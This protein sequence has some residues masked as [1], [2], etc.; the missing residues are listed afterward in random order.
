MKNNWIQYFSGVVTVKITG[1]GLER[2]LNSLLRNGITIWDVKRI[3][4]EAILFKM[5]LRDVS[6]LRHHVRKFDCKLSFQ[7]RTGLPFFVRKLMKNSGIVVGAILFLVTIFLLSNIVWDVEIEGASPETEYKIEKTLQ[8]IDVKRGKFL[9]LLDPPE[10]IQQTLTAQIDE[11][12]W[13]GV[14]L[15]GTTY[16]LQVVEK[17]VPEKPESYG[18]QNLVASKKAM[19]VDVFVEE[20]QPL[21]EVNDHVKAGQ[22]LVSG[23]IGT[24]EN[25]QYVSAKGEILGEIWYKTDVVLPLKN[26]LSVMTGEKMTK[27]YVNFGRF[28]IQVWGFEKVNFEQFKKEIDEKTFRFLKWEIPVSY[29]KI[30]FRETEQVTRSYDEKEAIKVAIQLA[31]NHL[32]SQIQEDGEIKGEKILHQRIEHGKVYLS[33]HFQVIENIAKPH[34]ISHIEQGESE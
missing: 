4:P 12:T 28:P 8:S 3:N 14:Q 13:V 5:S 31:K 30:I 10:S 9:F 33:L 11:I 22:L 21:V 29:E 7:K 17:N 26:N 15:K 1:K 16:E 18:P 34:P 19:I 32:K 20:G 27:H 2:L 6:T 25:P 23:V 24:E